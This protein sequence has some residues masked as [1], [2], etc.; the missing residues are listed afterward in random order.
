MTASASAI[1][2]E[3]GVQSR[4]Q[5]I[6]T[7]SRSARAVCAA[8][9]GFGLV[10][11]VVSLLIVS[12]TG[13]QSPKSLEGT[14][15]GVLAS[16]LTPLQFRLWLDLSVAAVMSVGLATV[17]QLYRLFGNL[18]NGAIYTTENVQRVWRVGLLMLASALL[19]VVLPSITMA[20]A[21]TLGDR[22]VPNSTSLFRSFGDSL[23]SLAAAGLVLLAS[24]IMDVGLYE[25]EHADELRRD[26]DLMI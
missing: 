18:A 4:I 1:P 15:G 16:V 20:M 21:T 10:G 7:F 8:L 11:T 3:P 12:F 24:W 2:Q 26:S 9:F 25:K 14:A 17:F 19:S 22:S 13:I 23:N 6:R 5:K